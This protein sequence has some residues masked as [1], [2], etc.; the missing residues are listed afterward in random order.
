VNKQAIAKA[1]KITEE[2]FW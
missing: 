2:R 1:D